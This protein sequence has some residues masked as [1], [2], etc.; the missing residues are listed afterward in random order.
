MSPDPDADPDPDC[1]SATISTARVRELTECDRG[2]ATTSRN[3][4]AAGS[5]RQK[6]I[7]ESIVSADRVGP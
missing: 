6:S 5:A 1:G 7:K 2:G 4:L 3:A